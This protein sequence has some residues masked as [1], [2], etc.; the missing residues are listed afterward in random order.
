MYKISVIIPTHNRGGDIEKT[1]YSVVNQTFSPYEIIIV[2]DGSTDNTKEVVKI[3]QKKYPNIYFYEYFPNRG[4]NYA[5]NYGVNKS[6]GNFIA[7]LDDDD[8]WLESKLK[9]QIECF[10]KNPNVGLVYTGVNN[11]YLDDNIFYISLPKKHKNIDKEILFHNIISTTSTVCV[12]KDILL[13]VGGFDEELPA[14]QDYDLWIRICQKYC[15]YGIEEPLINY[16]NKRK[17]SKQISSNTVNYIEA[18]DYISRKYDKL[19]SKLSPS[20]IC[21]R[22]VNNTKLLMNKE[23]RNNNKW[24]AFK[25]AI[26][27]I[28]LSKKPNTISYIVISI[29][30]YKLVLKV[31][32]LKK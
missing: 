30:P 22:E 24:N 31:R 12:R 25:Y 4:A 15:I 27:I 18:I 16:Y 1:I 23:M 32:A 8:E 2:S 3:I 13:D 19:F 14:L 6:K 28:K 26:R 11:I 20:E 7:F 21:K 10:I 17:L 29:L 9:K 5:R